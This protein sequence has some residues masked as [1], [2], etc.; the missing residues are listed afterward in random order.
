MSVERIFVDLKSS[1]RLTSLNIQVSKSI[2]LLLRD[3]PAAAA[4]L[5]WPPGPSTVDDVNLESRLTTVETAGNFKIRI[6]KF[7]QIV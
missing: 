2:Y 4:A 5:A 7:Y 3:A 6:I 1:G